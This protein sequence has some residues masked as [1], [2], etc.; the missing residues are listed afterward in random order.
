MTGRM[1]AGLGYVVNRSTLADERA[2][3][4]WLAAGLAGLARNCTP[5][6]KCVGIDGVPRFS[7]R[8]RDSGP[9]FTLTYEEGSVGCSC[10]CSYDKPREIPFSGV[11]RQFPE[12]IPGYSTH[13]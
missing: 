8:R 5:R 9:L 2:A 12:D 4:S 13:P 10:F 7:S 1:D 3:M 6:I 11:S